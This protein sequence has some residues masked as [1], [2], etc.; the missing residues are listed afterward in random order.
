MGS[1]RSIAGMACAGFLLACLLAAAPSAAHAADAKGKALFEAK[2]DSCH[3]L[4]RATALHKDRSGWEK[5]VTRMQK[6]NFAPVSDTEA[7][8]IVD[9]LAAEYGKK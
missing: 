4:S 6:V 3:A 9:Y 5:T 7:K 1:K 8:R 2:C